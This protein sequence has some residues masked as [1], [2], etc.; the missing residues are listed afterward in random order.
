M[1]FQLPPREHLCQFF[2]SPYSSRQGYEHTRLYQP[3][4]EKERERGERERERGSEI[5]SDAAAL[6]LSKN[7]CFLACI[8][9]TTISSAAE[10]YPS[11]ST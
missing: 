3:E 6:T 7:I 1:Q 10:L 2:H 9:G 5:L 11:I 4:D 8:S